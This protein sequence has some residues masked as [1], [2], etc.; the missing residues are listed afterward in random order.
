M[1]SKL[2]PARKHVVVDSV[3]VPPLV[4]CVCMNGNRECSYAIVST[5]FFLSTGPISNPNRKGPDQQSGRQAV[6]PGTLTLPHVGT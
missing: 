5:F 3:R 2:M 6:P 1:I 4:L